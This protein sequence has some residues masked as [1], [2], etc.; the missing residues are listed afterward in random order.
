M[1]GNSPTAYLAL[2]FPATTRFVRISSNFSGFP[3]PVHEFDREAARLL[4]AH[5]GPL[6]LLFQEPERAAP[7]AL[8]R[9][10]LRLD[11]STCGVVR[12]NLVHPRDTPT[13][14]CPVSRSGSASKAVAAWP[15][16]PD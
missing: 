11:P 6:L 14:L 10:A 5:A 9:F 7:L 13:R 2:A 3:S 16:K 15:A 4:D 12:S 1:V 8:E